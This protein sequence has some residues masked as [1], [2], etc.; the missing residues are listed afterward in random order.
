MSTQEDA[1]LIEA[2]RNF[3][4]KEVKPV[5]NRLERANEY[6]QDLVDQMKE[7][8]LFG[9]TIPQEYGGLGLGVV[10]YAKVVEELCRGWMSISGIINT[11]LMVAFSIKNFGSDA[12]KQR[13]LPAMATGEKRAAFGLTEAHAGS[14][15]QNIRT[16]AVRD[17]DDYVV[18]GDKMWSTNARTGTLFGLVVKTDPDAEPRH[19]GI[20]YLIAEKVGEGCTVSKDIPKLGYKGVESSEVAFEDFRVPVENLVG[21]EGMGFKYIMAGLEVG[22]VNIAARGVGVAQ[23]AFE[24]AIRYAQEREPFGEP[25][26]NHQ[27]IQLK[28]ADM[29]TKIE[30]GRLLVQS[31]AEKKERGERTDVEAGM[32]KLFCS[33]MCQEVALEAM[34]I[35]GGYGYSQEFNVERYYRDAPLMIIGEGTNEIQRLVVA[36]GLLARYKR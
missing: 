27:A 13:F 26:C 36:K 34:R 31:A 25:I 11:H 32:A 16:R 19:R 14:D 20:S 18:N 21:E 17:G 5:A 24:D 7:M 15:A 29:A 10:T 30:A 9:A 3:V 22:R 23:A 12:L 2:V 8:G 28:L 1:D 33:E 35:H 4:E 6:P